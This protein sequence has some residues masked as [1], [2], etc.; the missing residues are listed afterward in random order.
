MSSDASGRWLARSPE[1]LRFETIL[2]EAS[3]PGL[4]PRLE[5]IPMDR[6]LD[7]SGWIAIVHPNAVT[8]TLT[9]I[10]AGAALSMMQRGPLIGMDGL[11]LVDPAFKGEAFDSAF[12]MLTR[13]SG[14]WQTTPVMLTDGTDG[15]IEYTGFP[16][17]DEKN[18]RGLIVFLIKHLL[19]AHASI[20][21][22][23]HATQWEWLELRTN[24][25]H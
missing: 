7:L 12:L 2:R 9:F 13:P 23:G 19:P 21:V 3:V 20:S 10:H 6:L 24:S 17:Y 5:D 4:L 14:L 22:V 11:D 18:Q 8:R 1:S 25:G 16:V 15:E